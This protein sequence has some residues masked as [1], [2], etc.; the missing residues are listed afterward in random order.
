MFIEVHV[1][2]TGEAFLLNADAIETVG[3][4]V[5]YSR[6]DSRS[7]DVRETLADL[8]A[9]L[10]PRRMAEVNAARAVAAGRVR[11]PRVKVG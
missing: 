2:K 4:Y 3:D 9:L 6:H 11:V 1:R 8:A 10:D 5:I 7:Y